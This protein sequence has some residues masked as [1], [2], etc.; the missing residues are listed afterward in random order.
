MRDDRMTSDDWSRRKVLRSIGASTAAGVGLGGAVNTAAAAK[1]ETDSVERINGDEGEK[2]IRR[3]FLE[4]TSSSEYSDFVTRLSHRG[5]SLGIEDALVTR[6]VDDGTTNVLLPLSDERNRIAIDAI[7]EYGEGANFGHVLWTS[8]SSDAQ[9]LI[10]GNA[11]ALT[12]GLDFVSD[13]SVPDDG[14][15]AEIIGPDGHE[16]EVSTEFSKPTA[17]TRNSPLSSDV[18]AGVTFAHIDVATESVHT[19][20][21]TLSPS[22][23]Q[24]ARTTCPDSIPV[25]LGTI[26][27]C[28]GACTTCPSAGLGNLP[29]LFACIGCAACGCGVGCCLGERSGAVCSFASTVSSVPFFFAPG[30][31][32]AAACVNEGCNNNSCF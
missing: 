13:A 3:A 17:K 12:D 11:D 29:A 24:A 7:S 20:Q 26:A 10:T 19:P 8:A 22:V 5:Y 31:V 16:I 30:I 1:S 18:D 28:G 4:V 25:I 21:P 14:A 32:A 15:G 6:H 27:T 9:A 2:Y 23:V